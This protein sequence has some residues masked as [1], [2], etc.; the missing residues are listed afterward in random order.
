MTARETGPGA[1][2]TQ[3][4]SRAN[5]FQYLQPIVVTYLVDTWHYTQGA[6][7]NMDGSR[8][9]G[10]HWTWGLGSAIVA[11]APASAR[12]CSRRMVHEEPSAMTTT[13]SGSKISDRASRGLVAIVCAALLTPGDAVV[14]AQAAPAPA[15][16]SEAKLPAAQLDSLVAPIALYPDDLLAQ[17]LVASTY[18]LEIIQ[19][20]QWLAKHKELKD[21]ALA[22]E[23]AKQNWDPSIQSMAAVP[24]VV[25]RLADDIQWTTDLGNAFLD[26]QGDVMDACQRMRKKAKDKGALES[27][28]QQKVEVKVVEEKQVIVV[29][30]SNPEVIYVPSYSPAYVYGPPIYP[31]PPIYYPYYSAGAAFVTFGVGM[32]RGGAFWGGSCGGCGWG[33]GGDVD[34]NVNNNFNKNTNI[35]RGDNNINSGNRGNNSGNRGGASNKGG[36]GGNKWSH[37]PSHR[38]AAPYGNKATASKYGGEARGS[39]GGGRGPTAS[40]QP[41]GGSSG[42]RG[43]SPSAGNMSSGAGNRGGGASA[44]TRD[45]GGGS[46]GSSSAG[47]RGG[48][49]S[50]G[51]GFSGGSSGYSGSSARSAGSRGSSSFGGGGRGGG[52]RGGGGRR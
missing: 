16:A 36:A 8:G 45:A 39:Q 27:N 18:P 26:Q 19:L 46:R 7:L 37:N 1:T 4:T 33:G 17:T 15:A 40:Q 9:Q 3:A 13:A 12:S 5:Y 11:K 25:K 32:A 24:E 49:S 23:V 2:S 10:A 51:G 35:N 44:G 50:K 48:S 34:I 30:S 21:K 47:S 22:D 43:G 28:E 52:G 41:R 14:L 31:Y 6:T 20:S 29:Q 42:S 38:G